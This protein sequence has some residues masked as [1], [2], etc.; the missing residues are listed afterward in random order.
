MKL[1][2]AERDQGF[3]DTLR[4]MHAGMQ[5]L[6]LLDEAT[7]ARGAPMKELHLPGTYTPKPETDRDTPSQVSPLWYE[8][9]RGE[10]ELRLY[11]KDWE[12]GTRCAIDAS[13]L[14]RR[15]KKFRYLVPFDE[16]ARSYDT[17]QAAQSRAVGLAVKQAQREAYLARCE[18]ERR[19]TEVY[20]KW[21][22]QHA[23]KAQS[24]NEQPSIEVTEPP[25]PTYSP[26]S[27]RRDFKPEHRKHAR[28]EE[29]QREKQE[30]EQ[31]ELAKKR[32]Q[33]T[34]EAYKAWLGKK[35][36]QE[37]LAR[38][39]EQRR[40]EALERERKATHQKKWTKK[41]LVCCYS[42]AANC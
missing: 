32:A 25:R 35:A 1:Q 14:E 21:R 15:R 7:L 42:M 3:K 22:S 23:K 16:W 4:E 6:V 11:S 39:R 40:L 33:E 12:E 10:P 9:H 5:S 38:D 27:W 8:H 37:K 19:C 34:S 31:V 28:E 36:K 2:E 24:H 17:V 20:D 29:R 41:D 26:S 18:R 13:K 30:K